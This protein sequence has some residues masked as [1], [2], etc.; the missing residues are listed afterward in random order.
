[1]EVPRRQGL[2]ERELLEQM[3]WGT[4]ETLGLLANA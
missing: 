4:R 3:V 1:M 2:V